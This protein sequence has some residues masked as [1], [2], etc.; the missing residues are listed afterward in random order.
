MV[1]SDFDAVSDIPSTCK[2]LPTIVYPMTYDFLSRIVLSS[3]LATLTQILGTM[4][5]LRRHEDIMRSEMR[6]VKNGDH[7]GVVDEKQ[8]L[9][10]SK[11][12]AIKVLAEFRGLTTILA[13]GWPVLSK[14]S[15]LLQRG[16]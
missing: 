5:D 16:A 11:K 8:S 7:K 14:V 4:R 1:L 6:K 13:V 12:E 10:A 3:H 15:T 2:A 9:E